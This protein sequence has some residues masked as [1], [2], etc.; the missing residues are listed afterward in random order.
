VARTSPLGTS[1]VLVDRTLVLT[2][3]TAALTGWAGAAQRPVPPELVGV[4]HGGAHAGRHWDYAFSADGGYRA[5]PVAN[6]AAVSTG[7]VV[8]D[9]TTIT[10][11]NGGAPVSEEW[12]TSDGRLVLDGDAYTRR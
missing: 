5:W 11:S 9:G 3:V 12:S 1:R 2:L 8:V 7:T 4:W 6:P 10:F